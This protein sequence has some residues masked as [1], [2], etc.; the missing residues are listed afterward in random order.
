LR[1]TRKVTLTR[2]RLDSNSGSVTFASDASHSASVDSSGNGSINLTFSVERHISRSTDPSGSLMLIGSPLPTPFTGS[3]AGLLSNVWTQGA[4]GGNTTD[5]NP[6][7]FSYSESGGLSGWTAVPNLTASTDRGRGYLVGLFKDDVNGGALDG[8]WPKSLTVSG[9]WQASENDGSEVSLPVGYTPGSGSNEDER[10]WNLVSNPFISTI[11]WDAASGWTRTNIEN[12]Y[13]TLREDGTYQGYNHDTDAG[14]NSGSRFIAPF[15]GFWV[16]ANAPDPALTVTDAVKV[17]DNQQAFNKSVETPGLWLHMTSESGH[18]VNTAL[19]LRE[20]GLLGHD[21]NDVPMIVHGTGFA[22]RIA[23]IGVESGSRLAMQH[24]PIA[25]DQIRIPVT[26]NVALQGTYA[27]GLETKRAIP[28]HWSLILEC[29]RTGNW[30]DLRKG[31]TVTV[32]Q[33]PGKETGF[34]LIIDP[35]TS[36]STPDAGRST[37]DAIALHG[38]YPNPFNPTTAIRFTLD[39]GRQTR[40]AVYDVLGR[41]VTVLIDGPMPAGEHKASFDASTLTSG[42]YIVRLEAGGMSMTRRVTLLK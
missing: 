10:G 6:N 8:G 17:P 31:E 20:D 22:N 30:Y 35:G 28:E 36:T 5:G 34:T 41:E 42:V 11:N 23:T 12:W 32:G 33:T 25:F 27:V 15:Q 16:K 38:A 3:S 18:V 39:A 7:V 13:Q 21:A 9:T 37:P 2:G 24:L 14:F 4:T 40:L 26:V 19:T 1:I 29:E